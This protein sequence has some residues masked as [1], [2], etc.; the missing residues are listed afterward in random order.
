MRTAP[1][2]TEAVP[3]Q[4]K[5]NLGPPRA[6]PPVEKKRRTDAVRPAPE[7]R[8]RLHAAQEQTAPRGFFP[9]GKPA[10]CPSPMGDGMPYSDDYVDRLRSRFRVGG[11]DLPQ[12]AT[13]DLAGFGTPAEDRPQQ[14]IEAS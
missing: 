1:V 7:F 8:P 14:A 6:I 13:A 11:P 12:R 5:Q 10:W 3:S 4:A 9:I 2:A